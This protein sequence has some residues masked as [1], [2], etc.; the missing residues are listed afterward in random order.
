M[1]LSI[2]QKKSLTFITTP[3][4]IAIGSILLGGI[5]STKDSDAISGWNAGN[6]IS[7]YVM[8]NKSSLS[9]SDIQGFLNNKVPNCDTWGEQTSEFGG[10]TRRQWAEARGYSPPYTCLRDYSQSGKSAA[11]I[12]RDASYEFSINPQVLI[13]LLQKEQGLV[14]DTW[15][16]STQYRSAT[17]YG[18]P[19]TAACDSDYYGFTNQVRWA[20]RMFRAILDDSPTW[21]TPYELGNNFIRYSPDSSCGGSN[22]YIQNR[23]TQALYNYTPYQPNQGALDAGWGTAHCGAYGNRNFYLYFTSWFGSTHTDRTFVS[24]NDPRWMQL[25]NNTQKIDPLTGQAVDGVLNAGRQLRFTTKTAYTI[26]GEECLRTE[27]DT[28]NKQRKCILMS[29]IEEIVVTVTPI[30]EKVVRAN[31]NTFKRDVRRGTIVPKTGIEKDRLITVSAKTTIG[32]TEYYISKYDNNIGLER[33]LLV[34]R[35][36]NSSV[37]E[38]VIPIL[39]DLKSTTR[40]ITPSTGNSI[41]HSLP[42]GMR[43][44]YTSRTLVNGT[45]Y[46]RTEADT[47]ANLDKAIPISNLQLVEYEAFDY[48]RW[49]EVKQDTKKVQPLSKG[50]TT[51][52]LSAGQ[53]LRFMSKVKVNGMWYYRTSAD[54]GANFDRAVKSS[55]LKNI[56]YESFVSPRKMRL[57]QD[58]SKYIPTREDATETIFPA[59]LTRFF[60]SK[61][62]INGIWY[63]RTSHDTEHGIDNAFRASDLEEA[64]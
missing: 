21:Y 51:I 7:D 64:S 6:I 15:P 22:V 5:L 43:R 13:V 42:S 10:G 38:P 26:N 12:I 56:Q 16:I 52:N 41:D 30:T 60:D 3:A 9:T 25:K 4:L 58:V 61:I 1:K 11:Q 18:C 47:N 62:Q 57:S 27:T 24:L 8:T 2:K 31:A 48:P 45:W 59:G 32:N 14:T 63:Y 34:S 54:T 50:T 49:M 17:G 33:G 28:A 37:Y 29:D 44:F 46:Y 23:S 19:D 35:F 36:P 39:Y 20:A 53:Q 55:D 40:K